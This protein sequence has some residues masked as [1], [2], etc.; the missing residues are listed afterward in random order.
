VLIIGEVHIAKKDFYIQWNSLKHFLGKLNTLG[1]LSTKMCQEGK[2]ENMLC[3]EIDIRFTRILF[4]INSAL[5]G[6]IYPANHIYL[7]A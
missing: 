5:N 3:I 6:T 4:H 1:L 7:I 2:P